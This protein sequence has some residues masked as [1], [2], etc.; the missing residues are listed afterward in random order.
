LSGTSSISRAPLAGTPVHTTF[1]TTE[2]ASCGVAV[3]PA[4]VPAPVC[5]DLGH[6]VQAGESVALALS[7]TGEGAFTYE[8]VDQPAHGTLSELDVDAGTVRYT[9]EPSFQGT[10]TFT[11]RAT[12]A[13][14]PSKLATVTIDVHAT[15][16]FRV[17]GVKRNR[18]RGTTVLRVALPAAGSL[19]VAGAGI[20]GVTVVAQAPRT[21]R[22]KVRAV[23]RKARWL[24]RK[25]KVQVR[26]RLTYEPVGGAPRT[27]TK[28]LR[29]V[30]K[31]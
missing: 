24:R 8:V 17:V 29:L 23:G 7:C 6:S 18:K 1:I 25:G 11:Y 19:R 9:P 27:K 22:V 10:D 20:K 2:L 28:R 3:T 12:N 4:P 15:S 30:R 5:T 31:R 21:V 16:D 14:G 26:A 13:G